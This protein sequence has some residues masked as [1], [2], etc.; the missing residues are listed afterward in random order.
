MTA[1]AAAR[2]AIA[3]RALVISREGLI[4]TVLPA[5]T[6]PRVRMLTLAAP[7]AHTAMGSQQALRVVKA[8]RLTS[9]PILASVSMRRVRIAQTHRARPKDAVRIPHA[10][11]KRASR[12]H[13]QPLATA[14][15][16]VALTVAIAHCAKLVSWPTAAMAHRVQIVTPT[17]TAAKAVRPVAKAALQA[18]AVPA[19]AAPTGPPAGNVTGPSKSPRD[20]GFRV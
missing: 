10:R 11:M 3:S 16:V 17:A 8:V 7:S 2:S 18:V 12:A 15:P 13:E 6:G 4:A 20:P 9:P 5:T 19:I 1:A 14:N